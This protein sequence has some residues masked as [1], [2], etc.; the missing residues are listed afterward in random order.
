[1]HLVSKRAR[2]ANLIPQPGALYVGLWTSTFFHSVAFLWASQFK[3]QL[4]LRSVPVV[5]L[6][7]GTCHISGIR[8]DRTLVIIVEL[9]PHNGRS[10]ILYTPLPS[11]GH[12]ECQLYQLDGTGLNAHALRFSS[13]LC[14]AWKQTRNP[15]CLVFQCQM[16]TIYTFRTRVNSLMLSKFSSHINK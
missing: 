12:N 6:S 13:G 5:F 9:E 14:P 15:V 11:S 2:E 1:M 8:K 7:P 3:G 16:Y 4:W 10:H